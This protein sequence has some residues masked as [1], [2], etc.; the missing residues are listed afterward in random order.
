MI[1]VFQ[2]VFCIAL[3]LSSSLQSPQCKPQIPPSEGDYEQVILL[4][5]RPEPSIFS[6]AAENLKN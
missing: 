6:I 5:F 2:T 4:P 3:A 1:T